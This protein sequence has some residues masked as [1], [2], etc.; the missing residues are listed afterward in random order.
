MLWVV[1]TTLQNTARLG[2]ELWFL[3]SATQ[4]Q[5]KWSQQFDLTVT[6]DS[7]C[8]LEML[9]LIMRM[10]ISNLFIINSAHK[11]EDI[12][13]PRL[14]ADLCI[15]VPGKLKACRPSIQNTTFCEGS[16]GFR[17]LT[18]FREL[19]SPGP[20]LSPASALMKNLLPPPLLQQRCLQP[21]P[22]QTRVA[23][24]EDI[25]GIRLHTSRVSTKDGS[26][27][28][29]ITVYTQQIYYCSSQQGFDL[30]CVPAGW[31]DRNC[32]WGTSSI[33]HIFNVC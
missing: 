28:W 15:A 26:L 2:A 20:G 14:A 8:Y 30:F 21:V 18:W 5:T 10:L 11:K 1:A 23:G 19:T 25:R 24:P 9:L 16:T 29:F 32:L 31:I 22:G 3:C 17:S 4:T 7:T 13:K 33:P 12:A 27:T 6:L